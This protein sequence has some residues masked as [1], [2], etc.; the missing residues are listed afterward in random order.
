VLLRGEFLS[1]DNDNDDSDVELVLPVWTASSLQQKWSKFVL[2]IVT[3][4]ICLTNRCPKKVVKVSLLHYFVLSIIIFCS[5]C[6]V[7]FSRLDNDHYYNRIH[8]IFLEQNPNITS[9]DIYHPSREYLKDCAKFLSISKALQTNPS[10]CEKKKRADNTSAVQLFSPE[11]T[12]GS[13]DVAVGKTPRPTGNK[14]A[15]RRVEEEK[16][17]E[18]VASKLKDGFSTGSTGTVVAKA[19]T[20]F[21]SVLSSMFNQW[22]ERN[23]F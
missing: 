15:K 5:H 17:M 1:S 19:I 2:P 21:S 13:D 9:F 3:K 22:Q 10:I 7:C 6:F 4:F 11:G 16:I 12:S 23:Q 8:L 18:N 20:D 14:A